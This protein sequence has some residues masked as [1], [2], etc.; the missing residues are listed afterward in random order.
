MSKLT[1][2]LGAE[3]GQGYSCVVLCIPLPNAMSGS[4]KSTINCAMID[5]TLWLLS[6][7]SH[8]SHIAQHPISCYGEC[9]TQAFLSGVQSQKELEGKC[10]SGC[11]WCKM[12]QRISRKCKLSGKW[13]DPSLLKSSQNFFSSARI[14]IPASPTSTAPPTLPHTH[15]AHIFTLASSLSCCYSLTLGPFTMLGSPLRINSTDLNVQFAHLSMWLVRGWPASLPDPQSGD[16]KHKLFTLAL[17]H[18]PDIYWAWGGGA[19]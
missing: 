15:S 11:L 8:W 5:R 18:R 7:F 6:Y 12:S 13:L 17:S 14:Q 3:W 4:Y 2:L 1:L 16:S 19:Q 9:K 10:V